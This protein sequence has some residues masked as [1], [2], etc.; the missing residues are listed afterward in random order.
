MDENLLISTLQNALAIDSTAVSAVVGALVT[1]IFLRRDTSVQEFE[2]VKAGK[3]DEVI[4]SL[5]NSGRMSYLEF[6]KCKN[7]LKIA[8]IADK[9]FKE[10]NSSENWKRDQQYDF[11]WF[12]RFFEYASNIS[13]ADMQRIWGSVMAGEINAPGTVSFTLLHSLFMMRK[14]QATLF[15]ELCKYTLLDI[16]D[17]KPQLFIFVSTNR[18]LFARRNIT[19]TSLRE[20]ERLGLV[21]C[22][23]RDEYIFKNKKV[24]RRGN[25]V[26]EV[27]G[28][29]NNENK[30][31]AGN[32]KLTD[33]GQVLYS[34]IDEGYR[35][36]RSEIVN[37]IITRLLKRNCTVY[38]N[39]RLV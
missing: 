6:Y 23:F 22:D 17:L 1:T 38:I 15:G 8:K 10:N 20:L 30:I 31:K 18:E 35:A 14:E 16:K 13:N 12:T 39:G 24:L 33:D 36:Y 21:E 9:V 25:K 2:K 11:D 29:A 7:F 34:V 37:F 28:N 3:F 27:Y 32:V 19:P 26:I 4:D 5:L